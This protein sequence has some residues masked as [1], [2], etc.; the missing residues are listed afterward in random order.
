MILSEI[1]SR[2]REKHPE[3]APWQLESLAP[4]VVSLLEK[5]TRQFKA[6]IDELRDAFI[7]ARAQKVDAEAETLALREALAKEQA[8]YADIY[9]KLLAAEED[10][11]ELRLAASLSPSTGS[12]SR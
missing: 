12:T 10:I 11:V 6:E 9:A 8:R 2:L 5:E 7:T 3:L 4:L 1:T